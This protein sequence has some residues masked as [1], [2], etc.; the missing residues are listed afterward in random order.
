M[1]KQNVK[2]SFTA[3]FQRSLAAKRIYEIY[4]GP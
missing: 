2:H 3:V 4:V 1:Y